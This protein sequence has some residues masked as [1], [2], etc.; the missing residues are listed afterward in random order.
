VLSVLH[1]SQGSARLVTA[2]YRIWHHTT[3]A[4]EA[5]VADLERRKR[6]R[7]ARAC[8]A[9]L[10]ANQPVEQEQTVRIWRDGQKVRVEH[11]GGERDGHY[12]VAD[13]PL[14][15]MWDERTG[16]RSN[17]DDP[18]VGNHV[19]QELETMLDPTSLL[20]SL[21]FDVTGN[22]EI[23]G[24]STFT[25]RATPRPVDDRFGLPIELGTL[26][27][28]GDYY[29]LEV[30]RERGVLLAAAAVRN[31]EPFRAISALSIQFDSQLAPDI[32]RFEPPAGE[33]IQTRWSGPRMRYVTLVEAQQQA[34]FT[35]LMLDTVPANW[36]VQCRLIDASK[37]PRS[38]ATVVVSYRSTDGHESISINQTAAD[39]LYRPGIGN[40]E[41]WETVPA[42]R[43]TIR[44]V[45]WG[46]AQARF[47]DHGTY[48]NLM[49]DN[50]TRDQLIKIAAKMRPAPT[51][52]EI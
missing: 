24:R 19:G 10:G 18:S 42:D 12:A 23:A 39:A 11:H 52:S 26:G 25:V 1:D 27:T 29:E 8:G 5:F 47:E 48:V 44:P 28:G 46:Q 20:S 4:Q 37:R 40:E 16:A 34:P 50:L 6:K 2:S 45:S 3:R 36:Q 41:D 9:G 35:V 30:D 15:W 38:S 22:S 33:Q 21:R 31:S 13:P 7:S 17:E 51:T 14:W 32:F 43:R 49:S